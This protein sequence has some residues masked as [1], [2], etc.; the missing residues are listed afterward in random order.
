MKCQTEGN[1][2]KTTLISEEV[3]QGRHKDHGRLFV[4]IRFDGGVWVSLHAP[5]LTGHLLSPTNTGN[6]AYQ[7]LGKWEEMTG[8][9]ASLDLDLRPHCSSPTLLTTRPHPWKHKKK[10]FIMS[11]ELEAEA[12]GLSCIFKLISSII[13]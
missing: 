1:L 2:I 3:R 7:G 11:K 8:V 6:S 10:L 5:W 9:F 12:E 13:L 4:Y